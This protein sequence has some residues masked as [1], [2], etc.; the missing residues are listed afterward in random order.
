[1]K[2]YFDIYY[3]AGRFDFEGKTLAEALKKTFANRARAFTVEQ[4]D[5]MLSFSANDAMQKKWTAF[6]KKVNTESD[7]DTVIETIRLF[8]LPP[9]QAAVEDEIY[10]KLW[11]AHEQ[12]WK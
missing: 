6:C 3:L 4:F 1:M 2:D 5:Q 10:S 8:L 7:F 11:K 12:M 9:Y